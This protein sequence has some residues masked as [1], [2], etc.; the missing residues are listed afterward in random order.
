[1]HMSNKIAIAPT[2]AKQSNAMQRNATSN[3]ELPI[4]YVYP[5]AAAKARRAVSLPPSLSLFRPSI[6]SLRLPT[7]RCHDP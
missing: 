4:G 5:T 2:Q 6:R 7:P 3:P 1:M